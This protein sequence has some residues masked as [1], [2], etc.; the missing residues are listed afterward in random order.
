MLSHPTQ[1]RESR[2]EPHHRDR[3]PSC[4][5]FLANADAS[6][7]WQSKVT[8]KISEARRFWD[9]KAEDQDYLQLFPKG[10]NQLKPQ[11]RLHD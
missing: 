2:D 7:I 11:G 3:D 1:R 6:G 8:T 5:L 9:A 4:G 10:K